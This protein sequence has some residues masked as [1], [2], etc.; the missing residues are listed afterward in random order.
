MTRQRFARVGEGLPTEADDFLTEEDSNASSWTGPFQNFS[1]GRAR[2]FLGMIAPVFDAPS[3][4]FDG[5]RGRIRR[6][7]TIAGIA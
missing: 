3:D 6:H 2:R 7:R 5:P 1:Q 4:V